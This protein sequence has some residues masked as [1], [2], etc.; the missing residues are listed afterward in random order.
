MFSGT[1]DDLYFAA[2][3]DASMA[4]PDLDNKEPMT[5]QG[6]ISASVTNARLRLTGE[7]TINDETNT[8]RTEGPLFTITPAS[9]FTVRVL[10]EGYHTGSSSGNDIVNL[11]PEYGLGGLRIKLY[12]DNSGGIGKLVGTA[13]SEDSYDERDPYNRNAGNDRFANVN[14]VFTDLAD[15]NYWVV[16]EHMNHLP[17]MSR[18]AAPFQYVGDD[19]EN[20]EHRIRLGF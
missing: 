9:N 12:E 7:Y 20:L 13:E 11:A 10:L 5:D 15:G 6:P 16:V 1:N 17:V 3:L 8:I 18:F 2:L 19:I 14:F 4:D